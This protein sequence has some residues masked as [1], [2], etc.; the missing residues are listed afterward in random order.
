MIFLSVSISIPKLS[1]IDHPLFPK[2]ILSKKKKKNLISILNNQ[3]SNTSF[4]IRIE[5]KK[6][7]FF[8]RSS[9]ISQTTYLEH[10]SWKLFKFSF[11]W[12]KIL[13]KTRIKFLVQNF[14]KS[15]QLIFF[16]VF[17]L[18]IVVRFSFQFMSPFSLQLINF[19]REI[20]RK[21]S[22]GND[23]RV[24]NTVASSGK[25]VKKREWELARP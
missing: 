22:V 16:L 18:L 2:I 10:Q 7:K 1:S 21:D 8:P 11:N 13:K 3:I 14:S 6:V 20:S 4:S 24:A 12:L 9:K 23:G 5:F 19:H 15:N 25:E 17:Y